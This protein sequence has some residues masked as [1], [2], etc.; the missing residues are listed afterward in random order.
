MRRKPNFRG[1]S[2]L[3]LLLQNIRNIFHRTVIPQIH[4]STA[5]EAT[6]SE[7]GL[8]ETFGVSVNHIIVTNTG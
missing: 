6:Y 2:I 7:L 3:T 1:G 4:M 8:S 5:T